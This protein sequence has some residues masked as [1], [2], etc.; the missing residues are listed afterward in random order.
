MP[1][2]AAE[3]PSSPNA[4]CA[5]GVSQIQYGFMDV[6]RSS[7]RSSEGL[8]A[9]P[10]ISPSLVALPCPPMPCLNFCLHAIPSIRRSR[11]KNWQIPTLFLRVAPLLFSSSSC[12]PR[13]RPLPAAGAFFT[14]GQAVTACRHHVPSLFLDVGSAGRISRLDIYL[15]Q[16]GTR[17]VL[18]P[19]RVRLEG[20]FRLSGQ[21]FRSKSSHASRPII[22]PMQN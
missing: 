9:L 22:L 4:K 3:M 8:S 18:T 6:N 1:A 5:G 21:C 16:C 12:G 19:D 11:G 17:C 15:C 14:A 20:E 2:G 7:E 13:V 10:G